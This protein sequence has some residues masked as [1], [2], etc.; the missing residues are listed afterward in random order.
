MACHDRNLFKESELLGE[1]MSTLTKLN[2]AI[3]KALA[4]TQ[5][6]TLANFKQYLKTKDDVDMEFMEELI[7]DFTSII[8]QKP[9]KKKRVPSA[10]TLYIQYQMSEL[11]KAAPS[12]TGKELMTRAVEAWKQLPDE[13]KSKLKQ[14]LKDEPELGGRALVSK[15]ENA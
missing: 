8:A 12:L 14:I 3:A 15:A 5:Q 13:N 11:K 6:E 4:E 2:A 9:E 7:N 1:V 10:Y